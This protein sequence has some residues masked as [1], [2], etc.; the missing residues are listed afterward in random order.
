[1][2][3]SGSSVEAKANLGKNKVSGDALPDHGW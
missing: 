2:I 3:I 1:M